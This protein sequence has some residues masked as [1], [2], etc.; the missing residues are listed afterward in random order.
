MTTT[1][2]RPHRADP[3]QPWCRPNPTPYRRVLVP[4]PW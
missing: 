3:H 2:T 4:A 1:Q